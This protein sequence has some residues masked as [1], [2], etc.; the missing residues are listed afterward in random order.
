MPCDR[1]MR[2]IA[3][4]IGTLARLHVQLGG[5]RNELPRDGIVGIGRVD[6]RG[7]RRASS[8]RH[9]ARRPARARRAL[10]RRKAARRRVRRGCARSRASFG[11]RSCLTT[12][13]LPAAS[14]PPVRSA[15]APLASITSRSKP[16]ATPLACGICGE[17]R[18]KFL[19]QRIALAIAALLLVHLLLNR[20]RCSSASVNSPKPLASS[21]PQA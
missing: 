18:Q 20:R 6:Q 11:H 13:H 4:R 2:V 14:T 9:S 16:S 10:W 12:L 8:P 15:C 3:D 19:V 17:R 21:T 1:R 7:H 5:A